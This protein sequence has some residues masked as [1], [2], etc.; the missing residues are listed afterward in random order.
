MPLFSQNPFD[1]DVGKRISV[2]R[3]LQALQLGPT[4]VLANASLA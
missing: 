4:T 2:L 3:A 1:Q